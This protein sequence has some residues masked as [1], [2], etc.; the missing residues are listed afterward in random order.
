MAACIGHSDIEVSEHAIGAA[1]AFV[2]YLATSS[3]AQEEVDADDEKVQDTIIE[4]L[5]ATDLTTPLVSALTRSPP[6]FMAEQILAA[7]LPLLVFPA[8]SAR[9]PAIDDVV[10]ALKP[11]LSGDDDRVRILAY[12]MIS[13]LAAR[14]S[15]NVNAILRAELLPGIM[16]RVKLQDK[17]AVVAL[18]DLATL[19]E[20]A[21]RLYCRPDCWV[22]HHCD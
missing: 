17:Q 20:D 15:D 22:T 10:A 14:D 8:A 4:S 7:L 2:D 1:L 13:W 21:H 3:T 5:L 19:G 16:K 6:P 18:S 12:M 9:L 11:H